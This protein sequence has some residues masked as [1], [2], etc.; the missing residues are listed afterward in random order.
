MNEY[1][2]NV[3]S[4]VD[5]RLGMSLKKVNIVR[6][7]QT[8]ELQKISIIGKSDSKEKFVFYGSMLDFDLEYIP[9]KI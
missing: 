9:K 5:T 2:S 6:E 4:Y 3:E 8:G 1:F 7:G